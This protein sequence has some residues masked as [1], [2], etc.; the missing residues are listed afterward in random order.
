MTPAELITDPTFP[1]LLRGEKVAATIDPVQKAVAASVMGIDPGVIF[2]AEREDLLNLALVLAPE[3]PLAE[4]VGVCHAAMLALADSLGSL[5]PPELA[6]HFSWPFGLK[7]NGAHCGTLTCQAST[8]ESSAIP[9]W[10]VIGVE[11]P[12]MRP[13]NLEPGEQPESTWLYEEGCIEMTV[14]QVIESWS[15]HVLIWLR[16]FE[17]GGYT[18]VQEHWRAKCDRLGQEVQHPKPGTFVGTNERGGLLLRQDG[19]TEIFEL[20]GQLHGS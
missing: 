9:D 15:R 18:A 6:V 3:T 16:T 2:Y 17:E 14:P 12:F 1:P 11:V 20:T 7:V 8:T 13:A 10:L 5:G 4:S 19:L